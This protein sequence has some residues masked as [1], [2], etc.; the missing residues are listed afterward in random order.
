MLTAETPDRP[1]ADELL[2]QT[3]WLLRLARALGADDALAHDLVQDTFQQ[4]LRQPRGPWRDVRALLA[5]MLRRRA[6][7]WLYRERV[8]PHIEGRA[9]VAG[10]APATDEVVAQATIHRDVVVAV[11]ALA[12]PY[13]TAILLRYLQDMPIAEVAACTGV[14]LATARSRVQRGLVQLRER[15]DRRHGGREAWLL[16]L[17][18]GTV[19]PLALTL[20]LWMNSKLLVAA[21]AAGLALGIGL[22]STSSAPPAPRAPLALLPEAP[23][24]QRGADGGAAAPAPQRAE[25][26]VAERDSAEPEPVKAVAFGMVVDEETRLPL[27][28][29]EVAWRARYQFLAE[30]MPSVVTD[31][32]G[33]FELPSRRARPHESCDLALRKAGY[34]WVGQQLSAPE[35]T[36]PPQRYD[37]G[38]ISLP[39]GTGVAGVVVDQDG[40][41]VASAQL[42]FYDT[43]Y[44][45]D[46]GRCV[47]LEWPLPIGHTALDGTFRPTARLV[48]VQD[49]VLVAASQRGLG[50]LPV[51]Q[52]TR[53][54]NEVNVLRI[55]LRPSCVL[56]ARV[57][58]PDGA[59]IVGAQVVA[60]PRFEPL[61]HGHS[62]R[63]AG[64]LTP[65][66]ASLFA[67]RTGDDG[68]ARLPALPRTDG[69]SPYLVVACGD[70][71][72]DEELQ[73]DLAAAERTLAVTLGVPRRIAVT[74]S[75]S[76]AGGAPIAGAT[77]TLARSS[78]ATDVDAVCDAHGAFAANVDLRSPVLIATAR[79]VGARPVTQETRLSPVADTV[80]LQFRLE[81]AASIRG[82]VVDDDN[83]GIADVSVIAVGERSTT[84]TDAWGRFELL[85]VPAD[86]DVEISA[87]PPEPETAWCGMATVTV[88]PASAPVTLR[89][90]RSGSCRLHVELVAVDGSPLEARHQQL[91][92][93]DRDWFPSSAAL[94][95]VTA[96]RLRPGRWTLFVE[97]VRG[98]SLFAE[99]EIVAGEVEHVLTLRQSASVTVSGEV[100]PVPADLALPPT[101]R[102]FCG[103]RN[104]GRFVPTEHQQLED[105]ELRLETAH[106]LGFRVE[107]VDPTRPLTVFASAGDL[108]GR[109]EVTVGDAGQATV[110]VHVGRA[111]RIRFVSATPWPHDEMR[112]WVLRPG[113]AAGNGELVT[114]VAGDTELL[115]LPFAP[116]TW[117]WRVEG[118]ATGIGAPVAYTGTVEVR[119]GECGDVRLDAA[120]RH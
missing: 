59:P 120:S 24:Q 99:F 12:E 75:V 48:S 13:R 118:P 96:E 103:Y 90:R 28:G 97:P 100:V 81:P 66:L 68:M 9:A 39:P 10:V 63:L 22:W 40:A 3:R 111:G 113:A 52:L 29:V 36:A 80:V 77:L 43:T 53:A 4:A 18:G 95:S 35:G 106:G 50:W 62:G 83:C 84:T 110:Q 98:A 93:D 72:L 92:Q 58:G 114:G 73:V 19:R 1:T 108:L 78:S 31:L 67:A 49:A 104:R 47:M 30:A 14:P 116:G 69:P 33:H 25:V 119:S 91:E 86:R 82:M 17:T 107:H 42:L 112:F 71:H 2:R 70:G 44:W 45:A 56:T 8:R 101:L 26:A 57:V 20:A 32:A 64:A 55:Q 102:L 21:V 88:A 46:D 6:R 105:G 34:A 51:S 11:L 94:G 7:R 5:T 87:M 89:L 16:P 27:A 65:D 61:G 37:A 38:V 109:A 79:A 117:A 41:P 74:G 23:V 115:E 85:D 60:M 54:R 15:L 76:D